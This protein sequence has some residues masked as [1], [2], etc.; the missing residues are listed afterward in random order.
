MA[1]INADSETRRDFRLSIIR[2]ST[3]SIEA[4]M[5]QQRI[6]EKSSQLDGRVFDRIVSPV[7][8]CVE[9]QAVSRRLPEEGRRLV[10]AANPAR[11]SRRS[12]TSESLSAI[13]FARLLKP[14]GAPITL[15]FPKLFSGNFV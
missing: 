7:R 1:E 5:T 9:Q 10:V 12:P 15:I 14:N 4:Y 13:L 8:V 2:F 11:Y 3:M 6:G